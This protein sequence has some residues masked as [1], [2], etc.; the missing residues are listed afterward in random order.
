M[1]CVCSKV[2]DIESG[3][4]LPVV[5]TEPITRQPSSTTSIE[6][7]EQVLESETNSAD[8]SSTKK[9]DVE[10]VASSIKHSTSVSNVSPSSQEKSIENLGSQGDSLVLEQEEDTL[11]KKANEI[12][13]THSKE[14]DAALNE[15]ICSD[16]SVQFSESTSSSSASSDFCPSRYTDFGDVYYTLSQA[17]KIIALDELLGEF[18]VVSKQS[19]N[20]GELFPLLFKLFSVVLREKDAYSTSLDCLSTSSS[21]FL[22]SD[23]Q[24]RVRTGVCQHLVFGE[25]QLRLLHLEHSSASLLLHQ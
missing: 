19:D 2:D 22:R 23:E 9:S 12:P 20:I 4:E 6:I 18:S 24:L 13:E 21:S 15:S 5:V 25:K 8:R 16:N 14:A 17:E 1:G 10:Q 11:P 3:V 7:Q